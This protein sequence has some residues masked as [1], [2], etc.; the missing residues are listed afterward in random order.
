MYDIILGR[1][2][3]DSKKL[4][5]KGSVMIGKQYV[6]MGDTSSLSNPIYLDVARAHAMLI[7]GK[8]G[9]LTEETLI[10]TDSGYKKIKDFNEKKDRVLSFNREIEEFGWEKNVQLISYNISKQEELYHITLHDGQELNLTAEHPLLVYRNKKLTWVIAKEIT[11]KDKLISLYKLPEI[12]NDKNNKES[13]RIARLLGFLLADGNLYEQKKEFVDGRGAKYNGRKARL[14]IINAD[15]EILNQAKE[16][17]DKEFKTNSRIYK[18][19][20]EECYIVETCQQKIVDK[21]VKLGTKIGK[22]HDTISIPQIVWESSK[23]FKAEFLKALFSCDGYIS[24]DGKIF[25]Y[26][27]SKQILKELNL[28]LFEFGIQSRF[29]DKRTKC[30]GKEFLTYELYITD[31]T[32]VINFKEIGFFPKTKKERIENRKFN[33]VLK[34]KNTNYINKELFCQNIKEIKKIKGISKVYDLRVPINNNFIANGI[35]SHNSGKS[36][37]MGSIAEGLADIDDEVSKN[38]AFVMLDTMG[39]YWSMKYPNKKDEDFLKKWGLEGKGLGVQV[40]VPGGFFKKY[41]EEGVPI[42]YPFYIQ[43]KE[44]SVEDWMN[45]FE[46]K[47]DDSVGVALQRVVNRF[48][49]NNENFGLDELIQSVEEDTRLDEK[50]KLAVQNRFENAKTWGIFSKKGTPI[51]DLLTGGKVTIMDFSPYVAMPGGWQIKALALGIVAK[52]IFVYR[53]MVRKKEELFDIV[54]KTQVVKEKEVE[55]DLPMPWLIVDECHE[56][57]PENGTTPASDALMTILREGRQ[58]GVSLVMATQQPAKIHT[59]AITQSDIVVAHRLT[60]S[61]DLEALDKIFLSYNNK[62]SKALFNSMP[63]TKGCAIIMDDKNERL[64][65]MQIKPRVSWHG[66]EDPNAIREVKDE[67]EFD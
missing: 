66:G 50:T 58:P 10:Y 67:F 15:D 24:K 28:I 46:L 6:E 54:N 47:T 60:A 22:K 30:N 32:S 39:V 59:D 64:H 35:I 23:K 4:K 5:T 2:P 34:R 51:K 19:G 14:R 38:L 21:F 20:K 36:Y 49:D 42:D 3:G 37:T 25:Y 18:K 63:R 52:K 12:K 31:Y 62:G 17:L 43:P 27:N 53:M 48:L 13:N 61:F 8:R 9:C 7:V 44:L 26:S 56:F 55:D 16:D 33:Q 11:E 1:S 40:Y 41:Q 45:A 65:T 29:R 57:L